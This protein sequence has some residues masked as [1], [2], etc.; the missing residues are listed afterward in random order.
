MINDLLQVQFP[1]IPLMETNQLPLKRPNIKEV[2]VLFKQFLDFEELIK[3]HKVL[4]VEQGKKDLSRDEKFI[5]VDSLINE[6][7][8]LHDAF[9]TYGNLSWHNVLY[10]KH[11]NNDITVRLRN[12]GFGEVGQKVTTDLDTDL[13]KSRQLLRWRNFPKYFGIPVRDLK[14]LCS[15][16]KNLFD[17]KVFSICRGLEYV[18]PS[19]L[20]PRKTLLSI[21][22]N[23]K[24]RVKE[25]DEQQERR[26]KRPGFF[27]RIR[28]FFKNLFSRK[29]TENLDEAQ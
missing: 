5:V 23:Y 24:S 22:R 13:S 8:D 17:L 20:M 2:L 11:P 16:I 7:I 6:L 10:F 28:M 9:Y 1:I 26:R 15:M 18:N 12:F 19:F 4:T 21:L 27:H 25:I 29:K 14:S 3:S